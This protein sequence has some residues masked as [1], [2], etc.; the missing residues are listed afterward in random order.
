MKLNFMLLTMVLSVAFAPLVLA[1]SQA[2]GYAP[3]A[4]AA[5]PTGP[6]GPGSPTTKLSEP[7]IIHALEV[8]GYTEVHTVQK[9]GDVLQL[10]A[11]KNGAPVKLVV[12]TVT[13]R[14]T[15]QPE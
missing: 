4:S 5:A 6:G 11:K 12:N 3:P 15:A 8:Q 10:Q 1:Q 14:A 7:E 13:R 2:P 9:K